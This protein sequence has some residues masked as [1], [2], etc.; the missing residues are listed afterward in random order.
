MAHSQSISDKLLERILS[1]LSDDKAEDVVQINLQ[2][3]SSVADHMVIAS[4]RST[5][6]VSA[7][8]EK[9]M[10]RI[11]QEFGFTSKVEG[12]DAG[13]W[14]LIDTGDVIVH[15]FRPEVREFYQLEKMWLPQGGSASAN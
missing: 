8:A 2:G 15:I 5:R 6:Q 3:K 14:V 10:D 12:K 1:S 11:K 4:G 9:L 7:M 13:D